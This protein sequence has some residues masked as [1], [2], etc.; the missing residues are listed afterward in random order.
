MRQQLRKFRLQA[1]GLA[2]AA[3]NLACAAH[4]PT[5]HELGARQ[6]MNM[7]R[8]GEFARLDRYYSAV[9]SSYDGGKISD[10]R[11]RSAFRHF[12][13]TSPDLAARYASWVEKMPNSYVAHLAKAIYYLRVGEQSRGNKFISDTSHAQLRG[14]DQAFATALGEL[15][16]SGISR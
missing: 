11:L 7:V 6:T 2:V 9:Q 13:D 16:K 10:R 14:M 4:P 1:L 8:A 15:Q 12:Y 5:D 3:T